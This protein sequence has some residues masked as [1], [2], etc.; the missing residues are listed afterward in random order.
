MSDGAE[1]CRLPPANHAAGAFFSPDR[2]CIVRYGSGRGP[3]EVWKTETASAR[4]IRQGD[5]TIFGAPL[6]TGRSS[7]GPGLERWRPSWSGTFSTGTEIR[8]FASP[9]VHQ[10]MFVALHPTEP[11]FACGSNV[12][13]RMW[14][15]DY[16]TGQMVQA[17]DTPWVEGSS[18]LAWH[19]DG[20]R[21]FVASDMTNEVQEYRFDRPR[22]RSAPAGC[23]RLRDSVATGSSPTPGV[24]ESP[25][26]A[27]HPWR[28]CLTSRP[29]AR[30]SSRRRSEPSINF[31]SAVTVGHWSPSGDFPAAVPRTASSTRRTP[32]KFEP[33]RWA[34][35]A[36][37]GP[38]S[39]PAGGSPSFPRETG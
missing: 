2:R 37:I 11:L 36:E 35:R 31:D 6:P 21:L 4:L 26:R 1:I 30:C 8:R 23:F 13:T 25:A 27:G 32:A 7:A 9:G 33:S 18:S 17:I 20:T 24:I 10:G 3:V 12:S 14:L 16:V 39:I 19:P 28:P 22:E 15:H 29:R 34:L 5:L 38:P